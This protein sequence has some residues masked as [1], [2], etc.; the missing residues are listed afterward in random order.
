MNKNKKNNIY[1]YIKKN[2]RQNEREKLT[3]NVW[4]FY[5][6]LKKEKH[7]ELCTGEAM[8]GTTGEE[9]EFGNWKGLGGAMD[10]GFVPYLTKKETG[11]T[12]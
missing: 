1:W 8:R 6:Q 2:W 7:T 12:Y 9:W 4:Q 11:A 10:N 5:E 3:N